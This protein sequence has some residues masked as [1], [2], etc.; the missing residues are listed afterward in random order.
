MNRTVF[1]FSFAL[2]YAALGWASGLQVSYQPAIRLI[3]EYDLQYT[4]VVDLDRLLVSPFYYT[5]PPALPR[6]PVPS[7]N[8]HLVAIPCMAPAP[9]KELAYT[10]LVDASGKRVNRLEGAYPGVA[11]SAS[12]EALAYS[13][14]TRNLNYDWTSSGTWILDLSNGQSRQVCEIGGKLHWARFDGRLYIE[15]REVDSSSI[16]VYNFETEQ[17]EETAYTSIDFSPE[18]TYYTDVDWSVGDCLLILREE[19][20]VINNAYDFL[21]AGSQFGYH[22]W[23]T[24]DVLLFGPVRDRFY[25][26]IFFCSTGRALLVPGHVIALDESDSVILARPPDGRLEKIPL[27]ECEVIEK[28]RSE[29]ETKE[30]IS[31]IALLRHNGILY[32]SGSQIVGNKDLSL[33]Y[34]IDLERK[35]FAPFYRRTEKPTGISDLV[36]SPDGKKIAMA[37]M[38]K[39]ED[40]YEYERIILDPDG[41][42]LFTIPTALHCAWS[43]DSS[44]LAYVS[45]SYAT[46]EA[47]PTGVWVYDL[48]THEARKVHDRGN[49]IRWAE[50]DGMIYVEGPEGARPIQRINPTTGE[51]I[52][53]EYE[54]FDFS[55]DG[56][57]LLYFNNRNRLVLREDGIDISSVYEFLQAKE[58]T[59]STRWLSENA[60]RIGSHEKAY[61]EYLFF[62]ETGRTYMAPGLILALGKNRESV[63]IS[64]YPDGEIQEL[65]FDMLELKAE[66]ESPEAIAAKVEELRKA[67]ADRPD[68]SSVGPA[69]VE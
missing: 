69:E 54:S 38:R 14:S 7:P 68:E 8:G 42:P 46:E 48:A 13:V 30:A 18:G 52:D 24:D 20:L 32:V 6:V 63:Y 21:R 16:G 56:K 29:K 33:A 58:N 37:Y 26:C 17:L 45:A 27:S 35:E 2:W 3:G 44:K 67:Q 9:I 23:V 59:G 50:F 60:V 11:W 1:R 28:G 10:D 64:R 39:I 22:E 5:E 34:K 62:C 53:T 19:N 57:F 55:P 66:G 43:P 51:V 4:F 61:H 40:I 49:A 15:Q 65:T 36:T 41:N 12:G 25:E 47:V 31:A